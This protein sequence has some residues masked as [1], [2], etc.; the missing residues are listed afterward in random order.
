MIP[1]LRLPRGL[2]DAGD[3]TGDGEFAEAETA[4]AELADVG[5][6]TAATLAAVVRTN[7]ELGRLLDRK[8]VV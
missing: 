5:V 8:S 6:T 2:R 4:D 1:F 3:E 7:A